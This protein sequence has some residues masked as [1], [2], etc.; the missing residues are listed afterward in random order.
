[1]RHRRAIGWAVALSEVVIAVAVVACAADDAVLAPEQGG[2]L[3]GVWQSAREPLQPQGS[4]QRTWGIGGDGRIEQVVVTYGVYP[5]DGANTVSASTH[6]FGRIGASASAFVVRT[7][8]IVTRDTFYGPNHRE[9]QRYPLAGVVAPH[10]S[11]HYQIVGDELRL[12]YYSYPA[13][14]PV[15][16]HGTMVRVR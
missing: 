9:V 14:A 16:T 4:M 12:T 5:G 11:T 3:V 8:S 1:M 10:D 13:D 7:D 6:Q 2:A 15:L